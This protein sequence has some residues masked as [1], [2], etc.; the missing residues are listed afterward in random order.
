MQ[1]KIFILLIVSLLLFSIGSAQEKSCKKGHCLKGDVGYINVTVGPCFPL[2]SFSDN[3]M[4]NPDAGFAKSGSNA[5]LNAGFR[6]TEKVSLTGELFYSVTGYDVITLT[7]KLAN[8]YP[9]TK[10]TT[11]GRSWDIYGF[12]V[13]A[14]YSYPFRNKITGDFKFQSGF[15]HSSTPQMI[16][17]SNTGSKITETEKS[18]SS[19]VY[20]ISIGGHYPLGRL[21]DATGSLEYLSSSPSFSNISKISNLSTG[22]P[23]ETVTSNSISSYNNRISLLSF[24][25]GCRVKF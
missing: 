3:D 4:K 23:P 8:D 9:G 5:G 12:M 10:W 1:E 15:M 14:S 2:G 6:L 25:I 18:A 21:F 20:Q 24:S 19:F 7:Q 13:G 22:N 17:T 16:I 11:S